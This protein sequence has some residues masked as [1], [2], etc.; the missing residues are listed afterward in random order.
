V[1]IDGDVRHENSFAL[2]GTAGTQYAIIGSR[3]RVKLRREPGADSEERHGVEKHAHAGNDREKAR[4]VLASQE[5]TQQ[6]EHRAIE[7]LGSA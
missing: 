3:I 1:T 5:W 2:T 4:T 7:A 6:S